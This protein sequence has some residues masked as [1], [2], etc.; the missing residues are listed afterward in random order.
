[1]HELSTTSEVI[2]ELGGN[3]PVAELTG[4][5]PKAVS[6]WRTFGRFPWRTQLTLIGALRKRGKKAPSSLWGMTKE[7]AA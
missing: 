7:P 5:N 2:D 3:G 1:M 4:S 6:M